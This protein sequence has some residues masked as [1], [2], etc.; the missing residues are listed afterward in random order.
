MHVTKPRGSALLMAVIAVTVL[1]L[2]V[3]GAI[4]FTGHNREASIYKSKGDSLASCAAAG[5]AFVLSQARGASMQGVAFD[6]QLPDEVDAARR[7]RISTGHYDGSTK[8]LSI[9]PVGAQSIGQSRSGVRDLSNVIAENSVS[10]VPA[11]VVIKCADAGGSE[12]EVEFVI[13]YSNLRQ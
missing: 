7:T 1:G 6:L 5:R 3:V 10:G 4:Q 9:T 8:I 12:S 2:L 11:R 13:K